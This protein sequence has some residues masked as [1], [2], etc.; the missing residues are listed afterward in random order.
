MA[1]FGKG[2]DF[3]RLAYGWLVARAS[4]QVPEKTEYTVDVLVVKFDVEICRITLDGSRNYCNSS[5]MK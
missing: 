3:R 5:H 2:L 1:A 4:L